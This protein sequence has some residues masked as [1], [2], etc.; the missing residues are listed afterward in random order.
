MSVILPGGTIGILGGGQLGRMLSLEARRMGYRVCVLDPDPRCPTAQVADDCVPGA[1]G[2]ATAALE[3][4]DR[5]AV[6]TL[7]TEHVPAEVLDQMETRIPVR[8]SAAV[9]RTIQDRLSQKEFLARHGFPQTN[10]RSVPDA[11]ALPAALEAIGAPA[12]LKSRRAGYDGK[13][14]ARVERG[15][16]LAATFCKAGGVPAVLESFVSFRAEISVILARGANGDFRVYPVAE[17]VHRRHILHSTR[18]P[19]RIE[20]KVA[21]RAVQTARDVADALGHVGV[22]AV[23]MFL[24]DDGGL[25]VN[26]IAP[27][28][29]NSGHYTFGACATSQFEQHVRAICGLPLGDP[30]L[31]SPAVMV[32]LIGD[33]WRVGRPDWSMVLSDPHVRLHLYG[34]AMAVDGRKMGHILVLDH[35]T[36]AAMQRAEAILRKLEDAAGLS[37]EERRA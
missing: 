20:P 5:V 35:D 3:L 17:N 22:M 19:A 1:L 18:A 7:D 10:F 26:E 31:L 9:L 4:A 13:G 12:V 32:N 25:Y 29:H 11:A 23:E 30:A 37:P 2:D 33:L 36:D 15:D 6:A 16:D 14:Q 21:E 27:R 34:K 8:P 28:T 24:L